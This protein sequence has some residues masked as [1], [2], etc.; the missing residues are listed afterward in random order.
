MLDGGLHGPGNVL[1][2]ANWRKARLTSQSG[3]HSR[4]VYRYLCLDIAL[5]CGYSTVARSDQNSRCFAFNKHNTLFFSDVKVMI[6]ETSSVD[7][8]ALRRNGCTITGR[9]DDSHPSQGSFYVAI[10][11]LKA[12]LGGHTIEEGVGRMINAP[13]VPVQ[14]D[15][16]RSASCCRDRCHHA[17]SRSAH[18]QHVAFHRHR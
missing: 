4:G 17:G 18:H 8:V 15:H 3:L 12:R 6:V 11:N 16:V 10:I 2:M 13:G 7:E 14:K 1:R 9:R 5:L